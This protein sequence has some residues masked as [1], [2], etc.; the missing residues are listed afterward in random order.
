MMRG[1]EET[2]FLCTCLERGARGCSGVEGKSL[3]GAKDI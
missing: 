3:E 1:I 2:S